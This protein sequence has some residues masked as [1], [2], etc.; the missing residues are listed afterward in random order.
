M[1]TIIGPPDHRGRP[2]RAG[3]QPAAD[4][5][6]RR[7]RKHATTKCL[8]KRR[9]ST[10]G[11]EE[12]QG[13]S[14]TLTAFPA[15]LAPPHLSRYFGADISNSAALDHSDTH[16]THKAHCAFSGTWKLLALRGGTV[17]L[18]PRTHIR[19][20]LTD[21]RPGLLLHADSGPPLST[22]RV[23][24]FFGRPLATPPKNGENCQLGIFCS[25]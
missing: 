23:G 3:E 8:W 2:V 4:S 9:G 24:S 12:D 18:P 13:R 6:G 10:R 11:P 14:A 19:P 1:R 15:P 7:R 22:V 16:D 17:G 20:H 5:R 21:R 25:V